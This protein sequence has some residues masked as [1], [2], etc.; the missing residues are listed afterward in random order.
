MAGFLWSLESISDLPRKAAPPK[1][2]FPPNASRSLKDNDN[3]ALNV[4]RLDNVEDVEVH[5]LDFICDKGGLGIA[6][7]VGYHDIARFS[8]IVKSL[9]N[10]K[11]YPR[12]K[13]GCYFQVDEV[14]TAN[15]CGLR[16]GDEILV[17]N[18]RETDN[19]SLDGVG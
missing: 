19:L 9:K 18:G 6:L 16:V 14:N 12:N 1:P 5:T 8:P 11:S 15:D 13:S 2:K 17:I 10:G 7:G 3:N 4:E